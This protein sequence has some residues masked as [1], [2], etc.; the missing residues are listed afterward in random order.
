MGWINS[1]KKKY[2]I[3]LNY[4]RETQLSSKYEKDIDGLK[5]IVM[6]QK[7]SM[8][9][10]RQWVHSLVNNLDYYKK[11]LLEND[12]KQDK[13]SLPLEEAFIDTVNSLLNSKQR[14]K[15]LSKENTAD[16]IAKAVFNN[17][18]AEGWH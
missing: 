12:S 8:K 16:A 2:Y 1:V 7:E 5:A 6:Q 14:Y 9:L 17:N 18:F 15:L 4:E 10:L 3:Q 11:K 13:Q